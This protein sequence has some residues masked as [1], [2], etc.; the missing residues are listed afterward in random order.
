MFLGYWRNTEATVQAWKGLWHRTGDMGYLD[1]EGFIT[2]VDRKKDAVRRRGEN[3]SSFQLELAIAAHPA[4]SAVAVTAVPS[5][6]G[7]DDIKASLVLHEGIALDMREFFQFLKETVPYY[8]IPRYVDTRA[9]LPT[10]AIGR[11]MKHVLR[12]EGVTDSMIDFEARG[13]TVPR[14]ERRGPASARSDQ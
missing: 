13:Y 8:A 2:F 5:E 9:A 11:V 10:N 6:L 14:T 1:G 4:V 7:D 12:E 3:V